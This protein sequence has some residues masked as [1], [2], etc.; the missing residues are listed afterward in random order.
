LT[1]KPSSPNEDAEA[2][3]PLDFAKWIFQVLYSPA[4]TFEKILKKPS[5][6]GPFL[7][8]LITLPLT[9]TGQ[10]VG[11]IK[12]FYEEPTPEHDIWTEKPAAPE[13]FAWTSNGNL[14][15]DGNEPFSGNYTV[16]TLFTNSSSTWVQLTGIGGFN[17]SK[18][19]YSRLFLRMKLLNAANTTPTDARLYLFSSGSESRA[20]NISIAD[21]L[22]DAGD[23]WANISLTLAQ[24]NWGT[25]LNSPTWTNITGIRL[26]LTWAAPSTLVLTIDDLFFGRFIPAVSSEPLG[27]LGTYWLMHSVLDFLLRWLI[28]SV[29]VYLALRS[30]SGWR[31]LWKDTLSILG[32]V[33]S[34]SIVYQLAL[35]LV[36]LALPPIYIPY[37]ATYTEYLDIYQKDWGLPVSILSLV[38]YG[39][40][41]ALCTVAVRKMALDLSWSKAFLV[42]FGAII[43]SI[44]L[45]SIL[46]AVFP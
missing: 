44:I 37:N 45:G 29:I 17:C 5:I 9:F 11:G 43:M 38:Q 10:Y 22:L 40:S 3:K 20:F 2:H 41:T 1:D 39:W 21:P 32:Y 23:H 25:G 19:E 42:G 7:I 26:G 15:F 13:V 24:E 18:E 8:L 4:K 14:T 36:F 34:V 16:S 28:L 12:F 30:L 33:F 31:G 35:A 46:L 27:L 6:R